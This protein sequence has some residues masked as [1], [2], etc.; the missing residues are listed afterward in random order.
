[1]TR[2][3]LLEQLDKDDLFDLVVVGGGASG[4]GVALDAA[5]R[6]LKILLVEKNDFAEGTSGRST[7]LA[8]GG[9]RYLEK[10]IKQLDRSQYNLVRDGLRERGLLLENARHLVNRIT[11]VTP[12][13]RWIDVP[14]IFSGLKLYDLLSGRRHIG[15]SRLVSRAE[16][17]RRLP[18][19]NREGLKAG[20]EY[21]DGQ[22]HDARVNLGLALT[23][24]RQ[25]ALVINHMAVSGFTRSAGKIS[26]VTLVDQLTGTDRTV[27]TRGV[28]NAAGPFVDQ[29]RKLDDPAA[30]DLI[31]TSSGVHLVLDGRF[32][33]PDTGLMI[34]KTEDGRVLFILPW[35]GHALIG[36]TDE[37]APLSEH[38]RPQDRDIDYLLR[39]VGRHFNVR[40][41]RADI[42]A[43]WSGLRPLVANP[44]AKDTAALARDHILSASPTG[45]L[46]LAGG[47]WT[48]YRKMALDTVNHAIRMFSLAPSHPAGQTAHLALLGSADF[49]PLG[50]T[51]LAQRYHLDADSAA[52]INRCYGDQADQVLELGHTT[53][54]NRPLVAGHPCL[55][56]QVI[57]GVRFEQAQRA[58]D[59]LARRTS[60]AVLDT[61]AARLA[62]PRVI[63]LMAAELGWNRQRCDAETRR[64]GT[65]LDEGI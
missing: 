42:K 7:K 30:A 9:V 50:G 21:Q 37:P 53:A 1:M 6:G 51:V 17:L 47:K 48:T 34:P 62:L 27:R 28:V 64:T 10:A 60:L 14:Y 16:A 26:A 31:T 35:E 22:F 63:E 23:A 13:Y 59:I 8:H 55:E 40:I 46:S 32:A 56:A 3:H 12:I 43:T 38:P 49:D 29:V 61:N 4:C 36:T 44:R 52:H 24:Q 58:I 15:H 45:L 18:M 57:Y 11:L 19:L 2:Q 41:T 33:P 65:L 54:S 25:G 5:S 39:H 20:V